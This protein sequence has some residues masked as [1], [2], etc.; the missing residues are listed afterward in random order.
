VSAPAPGDF[1]NRYRRRSRV[2]PSVARTQLSESVV[3]WQLTPWAGVSTASCGL[4]GASGRSRR[5]LGYPP[6]RRAGAAASGSRI[7][8]SGRRRSFSELGYG[9]RF[10]EPDGHGQS[11]GGHRL[12]VAGRSGVSTCTFPSIDSFFA[13]AD[14]HRLWG[15][16]GDTASSARCAAGPASPSVSSP[17]AAFGYNSRRLSEILCRGAPGDDTDSEETSGRHLVRSY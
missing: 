11:R 5:R 3:G 13:L 10:S 12:L 1:S 2:T 15:R 6:S 9:R 16:T 14:T 4:V 7:V 8:R 17:T